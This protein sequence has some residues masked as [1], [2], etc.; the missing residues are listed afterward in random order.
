MKKEFKNNWFLLALLLIGAIWYF[1]DSN[2]LRSLNSK[3]M[4]NSKTA[5]FSKSRQ[6]NNVATIAAL[7]NEEKEEIRLK[8]TADFEEAYPEHASPSGEIIEYALS[9]APAQ[10][11]IDEEMEI[12]MWAYNGQV[13]GP[14]LN[15]ELGQTIKI[16]F[17]NNLPQETTI[18]FHGIRVPNAMDGVPGVNQEAIQPGQSFI[19]EFTPKDTGTYWYH[20][21]V[22]GSEQVER[23]LYGT[24]IVSDPKAPS[25]PTDQVVVL[26]DITIIGDEIYPEF[27]SGHDLSHDG[28]W[29]NLQLVNGKVDHLQE[30]KRGERLRL[31]YVNASNARVYT[32]NF[33]DLEANGFAVDGLLASEVFNAEGFVLAPGGRID[34]DI[35]IPLNTTKKTFYVFDTYTRNKRRLNRFKV[36]DEV[37]ESTA[38][39][40][41]TTSSSIDWSEAR[42]LDASHTYILNSRRGRDAFAINWLIDGVTMKEGKPISLKKDTLQRVVF[43]NN[44]FRIHPM[45]LHGQFFKIIA[46]NGMP[47]NEPYWR[48]TAFVSGQETVEIAILPL[49]EGEWANHCHILEHAESGMMTTFKVL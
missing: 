2:L 29:G 16:N 7:S 4:R 36:L 38:F 12:E 23:G 28:R 8:L 15:V 13:P 11:T 14:Q 42:K 37:A 30:V 20:P 1:R 32:L 9:A 22:R 48:D 31:R 6:N 27:N 10:V 3:M 25:Y 35:T 43:A 17:T 19:Y 18:H 41:P 33:G 47:V 40:T 49:D 24:V 26:D 44:S 45:H 39:K 46:R 5:N 21:H 34:V